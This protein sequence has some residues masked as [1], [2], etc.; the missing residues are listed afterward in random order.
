M[1]TEVCYTCTCIDIMI[2][3]SYHVLIHAAPAMLFTIHHHAWL[4]R[5]I[6]LYRYNYI[7][8]SKHLRRQA[9]LTLN[10]LKGWYWDCHGM[11][12]CTH[13]SLLWRGHLRKVSSEIGKWECTKIVFCCFHDRYCK[14]TKCRKQCS[15]TGRIRQLSLAVLK[16][17]CCNRS[18]K[19][20]IMFAVHI[21]NNISSPF[22]K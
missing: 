1:L 20:K 19:K 3:R 2:Q 4:P 7:K 12:G 6:C 16:W 9:M 17:L 8:V 14:G 5:V 18:Y 10:I 13:V 11:R 22:H 15:N 21:V